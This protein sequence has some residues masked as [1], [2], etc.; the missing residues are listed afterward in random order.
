M[1]DVVIPDGTTV[2]G[3]ADWDGIIQAPISGTPSGGNAPAGFSVGSTVISVGSPDGTLTFDTAVTIMLP[4]V[5]G[6]VGYRP[7]GS[8]TWYTITTCGGSY[9]TP[10][11]PTAPGECAINNGTDTKIVTYHFTS[12][13]SLTTNSTSTS[14]S[15]S[16]GG[17]SV[18]APVC[19]DTKPGSAPT[20]L[21][22]IAGVNSV[23]L[24]WSKATSP[25]S[26]Y[27]VA[28]GNT[29]GVYSFG[30]P[31]VGDFNTT[32]Y[33]VNGLS[34]NTTYYFKVR[35]GNG[36][37][38]GDYSNELSA[39]PTGG[40]VAGPAA[41][42]EEG[43]LGT[44]TTTGE[45]TTEE[46]QVLGGAGSTQAAVQK[47][48]NFGQTLISQVSRLGKIRIIGIIILL[49]GLTFLIFSLFRKKRQ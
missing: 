24:S 32:S 30:N 49:I 41:G 47:N 15:T 21:S 2:A 33:T 6:T 9:D 44:T 20:L 22:A 8:D 27:L 42:F 1:A 16:S 23:T 12:F 4:G 10:T 31:N 35:A 18:S 11:L 26:Y 38:P 7:S 3:P 19:N 43:V 34:G 36:C 28:Y 5:T 13:G 40:F 46:G 39:T 37:M 29:S 48:N 45:Q 17:G 25:V 14:S